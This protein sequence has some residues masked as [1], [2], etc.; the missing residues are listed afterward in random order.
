[1]HFDDQVHVAC[2][3][4]MYVGHWHKGEH[5]VKLYEQMMVCPSGSV[6]LLP[7]LMDHQNSINPI[8]R[9]EFLQKCPI[10]CH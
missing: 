1:M 9:M 4:S 5:I 6:Q 2:E 10:P 3:Y 8:M 7:N